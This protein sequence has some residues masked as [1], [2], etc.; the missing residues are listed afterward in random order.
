MPNETITRTVPTAEAPTAPVEEDRKFTDTQVSGAPE[1]IL[2]VGTN[3]VIRLG[4]EAL[5]VQGVPHEVSIGLK[6][7]PDAVQIYPLIERLQAGE[8]LK[9]EDV[10]PYRQPI[11]HLGKQFSPELTWADRIATLT[12]PLGVGF[13]VKRAINR[14]I[15][16]EFP[17]RAALAIDQAREKIGEIEQQVDLLAEFENPKEEFVSELG[18]IADRTKKAIREERESRIMRGNAPDPM[19]V[20]KGIFGFF[21]RVVRKVRS[22]FGIFSWRKNVVANPDITAYDAAGGIERTMRGLIDDEGRTK[23]QL[24]MLS[25]LIDQIS[26]KNLPSREQLAFLAP[27]ILTSIFSAIEKSDA[28]EELL[29]SVKR[30]PHEFRFLTRFKDSYRGYSLQ[31]AQKA[32]VSL[33]PAIRD[34]LPTDGKKIREVFE[35]A[36]DLLQPIN[37][38]SSQDQFVERSKRKRSKT[39]WFGRVFKFRNR[40]TKN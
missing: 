39:K 25:R 22:F 36:K 37:G 8:E 12:T 18:I 2:G 38:N 13:A 5:N 10:R 33:L 24:P 29:D 4:R 34:V 1:Q 15:E 20:P 14:R 26:V 11:K 21:T 30:N 27:E 7:L 9:P 35:S 19:P 6:V 16:R 32:T 23:Q 31:R 40:D 28:D 17:A 3:V